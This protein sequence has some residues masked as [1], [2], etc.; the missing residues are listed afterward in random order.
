MCLLDGRFLTS[1]VFSESSSPAS[2]DPSLAFQARDFLPVS[3]RQAKVNTV[4]RRSGSGQREAMGV[5]VL[6]VRP[7]AW[8][9]RSLSPPSFSV[10]ELLLVLSSFRGGCTCRQLF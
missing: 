2:P 10:R 9:L 7:F 4:A 3:V 6:K 1:V 8:D 5:G